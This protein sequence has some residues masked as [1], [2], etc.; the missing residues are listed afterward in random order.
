MKGSLYIV[1]TPIGNLGD[2]TVRAQQ[3]LQQM[4]VIAAEDTRRTG[5]LLEALSIKAQLLS[6]HDHN[7][8][9]RTPYIIELIE[10]GQDIALVSDAGTPLVS[11]PGYRLVRACQDANIKVVP[12]PG[13]SALLAALA[14]AGIATD[15]FIFKGF[16]PAKGK[17]RSYAVQQCIDSQATT[18]L[19]ESPHRLQSLLDLL[20]E[21][22]AAEREVT[23]CRELTKQFETIHRA[24]A[25]ELAKWVAE[26]ANQRKGEIVLVIA[27]NDAEEILA[28]QWQPLAKR[29]LNEL[30]ASKVAKVL[31]E[32]SGMKRQELYQ[33]LLEHDK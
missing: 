20:V 33:W 16:L 28:S 15:E 14:T 22:G 4:N 19:Y 7:E 21:Q 32:F 29:L 17:A 30:P 18:V 12:I 9:E 6:Y 2:I 25:A 8:A 26:D 31:A 13:A 3:V 1:S 24:T 11:D 23:L 5:V 27:G 10:S